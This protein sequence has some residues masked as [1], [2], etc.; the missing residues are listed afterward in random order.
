MERTCH[1]CNANEKNFPSQGRRCHAC[2]AKKQREY[3]IATRNLPTLR[4]EKTL[5]GYIMRSYRN[6]KSRVTGVQKKKAHLY[7][8]LYILSRFEY[9]RMC[10]ISPIF[11]KLFLAYK[12]SGWK[13][14]LAPTPDRVNSTEGYFPDNIQFISQSENSSR[15]SKSK[16][17]MKYARYN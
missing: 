10:L 12:H 17:G 15:G 4:Y 6:M 13:Q 11:I 3:R 14:K 2:I 8:G 7:K 1:I 16:K 9:Y 5:N